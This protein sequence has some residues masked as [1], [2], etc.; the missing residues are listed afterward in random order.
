MAAIR[1]KK[2]V[3][4][5]S[6]KALDHHPNLNPEQQW[7]FKLRTHQTELVLPALALALTA[8]QLL[9]RKALMAKMAVSERLRVQHRT[10]C[11]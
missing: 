8:H 11:P 2:S 4:L 9:A 6:H 1:D 5:V 3:A 7:Q 10:H